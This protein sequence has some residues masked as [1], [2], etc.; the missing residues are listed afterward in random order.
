V[1]YNFMAHHFQWL[2]IFIPLMGAGLL[3]LV[4]GGEVAGVSC[5]AAAATAN[6]A[7]NKGD[8]DGFLI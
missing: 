5:R 2:Y 8:M 4:A 6:F 7:P 1:L 3:D